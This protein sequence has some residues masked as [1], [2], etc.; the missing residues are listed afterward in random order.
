[1]ENSVLTLGLRA[2]VFWALELLPCIVEELVEV[3]MAWDSS[4]L[5]LRDR[6]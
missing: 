6:S 3:G 4:A 2:R 5:D 1:M